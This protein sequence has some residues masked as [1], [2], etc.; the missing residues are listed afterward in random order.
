MKSRTTSFRSNSPSFST[1][2]AIVHHLAYFN[3][4]DHTAPLSAAPTIGMFKLSRQ[5]ANGSPITVHCSAGIGR[6]ATFVAIDYAS[7]KIREKANASMVDVIRDLRCQRFQ[8]IQSAIQYVFLHICLLELFAGEGV[9]PRDSTFNEYLDS[10][11]SM[12]KRY[13][14]RV[15]Q[16]EKERERTEA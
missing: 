10:Y 1:K 3:W 7:Q 14:K 15:E 6:S 12:I 8:A 16:K 11:V 5:L 2:S 13:N 4:P 9:L